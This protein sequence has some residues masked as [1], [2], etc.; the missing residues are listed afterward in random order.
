MAVQTVIMTMRHGQTAWGALRRYAGSV[1]VPLNEKG[2]DDCLQAAEALR[3]TSLDVVISSPLRRAAETAELV[4]ADAT[5]HVQSSL[6]ME[7]CFGVME[8]RT[9]EEVQ[10]F[11]PPLLFIEVGGDLHT[12]N[13]PGGEPLE[14]VWQ[15]AKRFRN[16]VFRDYAGLRTLVV[17]HGVFLQMFHGVLR[18]LTCIESLAKY[19]ANLEITTFEF[20]GRRLISEDVARLHDAGGSSF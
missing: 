4:A 3:S 11:D 15:R 8:G 13:P 16:V 10:G 14:D 18:G 20:V 7:R 12:V 1:D 2:R 5:V 19:P 9:W 17:S 6:C